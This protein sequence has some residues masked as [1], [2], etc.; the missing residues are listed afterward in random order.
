MR[1]LSE[2][3]AGL[4]LLPMTLISGLVISP[5]S[6]RNLVRSP[7][8]AAAI[9][10]LIGS[11]GVLVLSRSA[12]IGWVVAIT[13]NQR[14]RQRRPPHRLDHDWRQ[15]RLVLISVPGRTLPGKIAS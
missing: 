15:P 11:A 7:I 1:G 5:I 2:T 4:I 13:L 6:R 9:A 14:Q 12:W 10:C 8:I 3:E